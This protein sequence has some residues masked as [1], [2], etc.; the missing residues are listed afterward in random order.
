MSHRRRPRVTTSTNA[1]EGEEVRGLVD[2]LG[3]ML[4]GVLDRVQPSR[5]VK[6]RDVADARAVE[7]KGAKGPLDAYSWVDKMEMAFESTKLPE[8]KKVKMTVSFL[9]DSA[10]HWWT[11]ARRSNDGA[12]TM[13][14]EQFKAL[15]LASHGFPLFSLHC[16]PLLFLATTASQDATSSTTI[17]VTYSASTIATYPTPP[18]PEHVASTVTSLGLAALRLDISDPN[19]VRAFL[20]SNTTILLTIPNVLVPSLAT[21]HTNALRFGFKRSPSLLRFGL[22]IRLGFK[23]SLPHSSTDPDTNGTTSSAPPP[24]PP[25]ATAMKKWFAVAMGELFLGPSVDKK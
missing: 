19:L 3:A 14:W 25:S 15:F 2:S 16:F 23:T 9:D 12:Q 17:G 21:N 1:S 22:K 8:E 18:L 6:K 5:C 7:F 4:R 20:Y 10:H 24:L 11:L 13:T